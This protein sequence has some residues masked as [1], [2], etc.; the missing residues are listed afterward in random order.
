MES[1]IEHD[2]VNS[3]CLFKVGF[4]DKLFGL[5]AICL[6][7]LHCLFVFPFCIWV[8]ESKFKDRCQPARRE[9]WFQIQTHHRYNS[10]TSLCLRLEKVAQGRLACVCVWPF[11]TSAMCSGVRATGRTGTP[12]VLVSPAVA[13]RTRKCVESERVL[14]DGDG[15]PIQG[16]WQTGG[17]WT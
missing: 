4:I 10:L 8:S 2:V 14:S 5:S 17:R 12:R 6:F 3:C 16:R 13:P 1:A 9:T 11:V 15:D 7:A